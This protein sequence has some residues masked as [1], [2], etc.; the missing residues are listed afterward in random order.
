MLYGI[1]D[2][3]DLLVLSKKTEYNVL[4]FLSIRTRN[5]FLERVTIESQA[6][7]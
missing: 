5:A 7:K 3:W 1:K 4:L 6:L 2:N